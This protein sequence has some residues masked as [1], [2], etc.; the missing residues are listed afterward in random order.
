MNEEECVIK[1]PKLNPTGKHGVKHVPRRYPGQV[2]RD[3]GTDT[4]TPRH[5]R[6]KG[7]PQRTRI[8][9]HRQSIA[10]VRKVS[11]SRLRPALQ[12]SCSFITGSQGETCRNAEAL[13]RNTGGTGRVP[14]PVI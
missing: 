1:P 7:C 8:P 10:L 13:H 3:W 5:L 12:K 6:L 11:F 9:R 2:G 4:A 14:A